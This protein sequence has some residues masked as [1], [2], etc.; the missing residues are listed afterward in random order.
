LTAAEDDH[1]AAGAQAFFDALR[2]AKELI[3]FTAAEGAG[4]HCEMTNRSLLTAGSSTGRRVL[5]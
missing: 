5:G 3:R 1:L 2:C 4:S